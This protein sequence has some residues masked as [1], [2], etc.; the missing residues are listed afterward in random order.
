VCGVRF[1]SVAAD[2]ARQPAGD[3]TGHHLFDLGGLLM[4]LKDLLHRN[5]D[6]TMAEI[7]NAVGSS[8]CKVVTTNERDSG[9]LVGEK[10]ILSFRR[11]IVTENAFRQRLRAEGED[12]AGGGSRH[13]CRE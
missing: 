6:A 12:P 4:D 2:S 11:P 13:T 5:V 7:L 10:V 8:G 9:L 3:V 1:D